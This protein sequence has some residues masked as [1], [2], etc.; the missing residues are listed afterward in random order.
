MDEGALRE[1]IRRCLRSRQQR[2]AIVRLFLEEQSVVQVA[3][4]LGTT[5]ANVWVL[6][7]RALDRL[8]RCPDV[9]RLLAE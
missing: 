2:E 7:S 3:D 5:P 4:A 6:K 9:S 1:A 8:R